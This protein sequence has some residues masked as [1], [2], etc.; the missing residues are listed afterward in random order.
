MIK[1]FLRLSIAI[2]CFSCFAIALSC[3]KEKVPVPTIDP[4]CVD[5]ISFSAQIAPMISTNCASC[6]DTGNSTGYTLTNHTNISSNASAILNSLKGNPQLMPQGG[7]ALN[8]SLIQQFTC[9][10]NQGTLNN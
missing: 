7:P 2:F 6:H 10:I 5:T 8:D 1:Y 4:N 3:T 9:W